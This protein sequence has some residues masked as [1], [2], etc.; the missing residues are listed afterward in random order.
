MCLRQRDRPERARREALNRPQ[1]GLLRCVGYFVAI[2]ARLRRR[3]QRKRGACPDGS[4]I[5][6]RDRLKHGHP[7]LALAIHDG[8]VERRRPPVADD[9]GMHDQA[10]VISPDA[11]GERAPQERRDDQIRNKHFDRLCRHAVGDVVLDRHFVTAL[12][13]RDVEPLREAIE[14][15][16][17]EQDAHDSP[18]AS[19]SVAAGRPTASQPC[20]GRQSVYA[21]ARN[22]A[23]HRSR[24]RSAP[25]GRRADGRA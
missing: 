11:L 25:H 12:R 18:M 20:V 13:K 1:H 10:D 16:R 17:E 22:D 15:A 21:S 14:A 7:P 19:R 2:E 9:A 8:P 3:T 4:G 6:L 24:F 23:G 5:H